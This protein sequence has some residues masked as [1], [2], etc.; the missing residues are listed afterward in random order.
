MSVLLAAIDDSA[1]AGPVVAV[2]QRVA[3]LLDLELRALHVSED[4][5]GHTARKTADAAGV[6][7]ESRRS[8]PVQT[9][10]A[11][12]AEPEVRVLA[13]GARGIP[14]HGMPA[15]HVVLDLIRCVAKPVLIVPPDA[16]LPRAEHPRVLAPV[17]EDPNSGAALRVLLADAKLRDLELLLLHVFDA[18]H[19]PPFADHGTYEADAFA[20]EFVRRTVPTKSARTR[21]EMRAGFPA[22]AILDAERE[23]DSDL[24]VLAWGRHLS[25]GRASVVKRLL[26]DTKTPLLLVP[27]L[28]PDDVVGTPS[29]TSAL[30]R[31]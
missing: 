21:V 11:A 27:A 7:F 9:I 17:D 29:A 2:A 31:P 8:E 22:T 13:I 4:D 14:A 23:F 25:G 16:R 5:D 3:A 30:Q 24:V 15:G 12:V 6:H 28:E 20:E 10:L 18:E 19:M 1:A 26:T